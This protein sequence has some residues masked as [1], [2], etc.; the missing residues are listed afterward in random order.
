VRAWNWWTGDVV[1]GCC[2][3]MLRE[4]NVVWNVASMVVVS[5]VFVSMLSMF[6]EHQPP[7]KQT[8]KPDWPIGSTRVV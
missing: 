5:G 2:H 8:S 4:R 3:G 6:G 7:N 1:K